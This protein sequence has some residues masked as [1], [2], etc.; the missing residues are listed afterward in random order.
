MKERELKKRISKMSTKSKRRYYKMLLEEKFNV[1]PVPNGIIDS[2]IRLAC[3]LRYFAGGSVYDLAPLYGIVISEV[4]SSVW[5]VVEA[6]NSHAP[7]FIE[8]PADVSKQLKIAKDFKDVS[9]IPFDNCAGA[10]DGIL[11]WIE[12]PS[13]KE[14]KKAGIGR[15]KFLCTRKNKFGLNCQAVADK[16]GRFLDISI[17]YG[18]SS[19]DCLAF[20]ASD[21]C[22]RLEDGLLHPGLVLFGDNAYINR[23]YMATPF[24]NVSSGGR[25]DYNFYHSQVS[26]CRSY[27]C[28]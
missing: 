18:G 25:D 14:A 26:Y 28:L 8:Y 4:F 2:S 9:A 22:R 10:I 12:K 21:L 1:P 7:F 20:E 11:I 13:E 17:K 3:A 15:K 27:V 16:R 24:P 5:Y 23:S 6:V 19:S